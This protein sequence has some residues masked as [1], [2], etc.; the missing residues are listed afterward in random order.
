LL[1]LSFETIS[2]ISFMS[3][4]ADIAATVN[5][6]TIPAPGRLSRHPITFVTLSAVKVADTTTVLVRLRVITSVLTVHMGIS[7]MTV[8]I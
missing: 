1:L 3:D 2:A 7:H 4:A 8:I 6:D 5:C